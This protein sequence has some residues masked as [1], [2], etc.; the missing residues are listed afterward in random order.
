MSAVYPIF[1]LAPMDDVTETVF[2]RIVTDCA[3]PD[4]TMT[5]FV[6]VDGLCS[7]GRARLMPRLNATLDTVPVIAQI[8]GK[9]PENFET[10]AREIS[11][12]LLSDPEYESW[13]SREMHGD[14]AQGGGDE[15][16]KAYIRYAEASTGADNT[17]IRSKAGSASSLAG[18]QAKPLHFSGIDINF[19]CPDKSVVKN[20]CCSAL[21]QPHLHEKAIEIIR[22]T[23]RGAGNM[24]VSIKTRLGFS[25][26]DNTW[27]EL[28]LAEKP[29]MLTVHV[30]TTKQMSKVPAQWE[31]ILPIIELRNKLS[32]DTKIILNGDIKTRL[33]GQT[34][35]DKYGVDGIMIGRGVFDDP[36][37]FADSPTGESPWSELSREDKLA[38]LKK[39]ITFWQQTYPNGERKFDPLKKFCKIYCN[40]FDGAKELREHLMSCKTADELLTIIND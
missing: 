3:A 40:G 34:L 13:L 35:L 23:K 30:R 39:H 24:P 21:A 19:G 6:N 33:Q 14:E 20:E 29:S 28:L 38:I 25:S 36:Y 22:A 4:M 15:R 12:G 37:C 7:V 31:A 11:L 1:I 17:A 2:R 5:E 18:G 9:T 26:I 32:P 8:W 27:H 10:I 16:S